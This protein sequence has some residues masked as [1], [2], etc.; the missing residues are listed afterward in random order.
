MD[1]EEKARL[2]RLLC[3]DDDDDIVATTSSPAHSIKSVGGREE[4]PSSSSALNHL[5][6]DLEE[7][8]RSY[9]AKD[10]GVFGGTLQSSSSSLANITRPSLLSSCDSPQSSIRAEPSESSPASI[11]S[12]LLDLGEGGDSGCSTPAHHSAI[13]GE[14]DAVLPATPTHPTTAAGTTTTTTTTSGTAPG[15]F[16]FF[17]SSPMKQDDTGGAA[18]GSSSFNLPALIQTSQSLLR[19]SSSLI[20]ESII[21]KVGEGQDSLANAFSFTEGGG[22]GGA[23][24]V[25]F[26]SDDF[27]EV[28][29][30]SRISLWKYLADPCIVRSVEIKI[31]PDVAREAIVDLFK[32]VVMPHGLVVKDKGDNELVAERPS[33]TGRWHTVVL[34]T[35]VTADKQ[36][37]LLV[38]LV[39][40]P[41]LKQI[42][43]TI[44]TKV[45]GMGPSSQATTDPSPAG[46]Q[47]IEALGLALLEANMTLST[48]PKDQVGNDQ[49]S[50]YMT[51][52]TRAYL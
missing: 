22:G 35:G 32:I 4:A 52:R 50:L 45:P 23:S 44:V 49:T 43:D 46:N 3:E 2:A 10:P 31:R 1:E 17:S 16:S 41:K 37:M 51:V 18:A 28:V 29:D 40:D 5:D 36:R 30:V 48:M 21:K 39:A 25:P 14:G 12:A 11:R 9:E 26:P 7:L 47:L 6:L 38:Q 19:E 34:R 33:S 15:L 13:I 24:G 42:P 8:I 20:K 27:T